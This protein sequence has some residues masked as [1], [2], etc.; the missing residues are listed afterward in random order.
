[1]ASVAVVTGGY[2]GVWGGLVLLLF[3]WSGD[4]LDVFMVVSS[5]GRASW[6]LWS[7]KGSQRLSGLGGGRV[8]EGGW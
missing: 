8:A 4:V 1:M 3:E 7:V 6:K 5:L 2:L